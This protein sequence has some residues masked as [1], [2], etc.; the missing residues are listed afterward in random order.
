MRVIEPREFEE[1]TSPLFFSGFHSALRIPHST[2]DYGPPDV[3]HEKELS[4]KKKIW[5]IIKKISENTYQNR[6]KARS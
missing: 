1:R 4:A 5:S 6:R 3:L 2:F